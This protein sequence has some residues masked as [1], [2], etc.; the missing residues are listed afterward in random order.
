MVLDLWSSKKAL[1]ALWGASTAP[2]V[3]YAKPQVEEVE[4]RLVLSGTWT[5]LSHTAPAG[6]GTMMLLSNGTIMGQE[7]GS[8]KWD[9]LTPAANGSYINGTWSSIASMSMERLYYAS[10]VMPD[11][12]VFLLGGE[13]SGAGLPQNFTNT[14]EI[15]DPVANTWTALPNFIQPQF[16]DDPSQMLDS[17]KIL[18]GYIAGP[19]TYLYNPVTNTYTATGTKLRNDQSDEEGFVK[20]PDGSILDYE[21]FSSIAGGVPGHAQRYIPSTGTWVDAGSV[22]VALSSN[23]VGSELGP[24]LRLPDGRIFQIGAISNT[25]FY[26]PATNSWTAGPVI[27]GGQGADD[28]PAAILP[29]GDLIFAVDTPLFNAPSN[30]Y[31]FDFATNTITPVPVPAALGADLAGQPAFVSRMIVTPS[32]ELLLSTSSNQLWMYTPN[33]GPQNAWRPTITNITNNGGNVFTLT[34]TQLNGISEGSMYGDDVENSTN[35]PIV[36]VTDVAG[37]LFYCRSF[38]WTSTDVAT[39]SAPV[40]TQFILPAGAAKGPLTVVVVANGIPSLP[41]TLNGTVKAYYPLRYLY[42]PTTQTYRG[43]LTLQDVSTLTFTGTYLVIPILPAG[44]TLANGN[45]TTSSG[46]PAIQITVNLPSKAIKRIPIVLLNPLRKPLSTFFIGFT[47]E[48][49]PAP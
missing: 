36:R 8:Q 21:V 41:F 44:V 18:L 26:N 11:G 38:G 42:D 9:L 34:G 48:V 27:P 15:Y 46:T 40:S 14:G 35:Y 22:P 13:Y 16:G 20:L 30:L 47:I 19:Q 25:A 37:N 43:N 33:G 49:L 24:S 6:I 1:R 4:P 39:G 17:G 28:A 12:R 7:G 2:L 10:N 3:R 32:G 29:N 23:A 5:M 45:T 31:D